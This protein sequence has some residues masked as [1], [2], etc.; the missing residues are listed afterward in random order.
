MLLRRKKKK[1]KPTTTEKNP[2]PKH[3]THREKKKPTHKPT[4]KKN[5]F[6]TN[7]KKTLQANVPPLAVL[8]DQFLPVRLAG[9]LSTPSTAPQAAPGKTL[10]FPSPEHKDRA[11]IFS[12]GGACHRNR[13]KTE[14]IPQPAPDSAQRPRGRRLRAD[15]LC[16]CPPPPSGRFPG[17]GGA[18]GSSQRL[19]PPP[20]PP[21]GGSSRHLSA[22]G[23]PPRLHRIPPTRDA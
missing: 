13:G 9:G 6:E 11:A 20:P 16:T 1:T 3:H 22:G 17:A 2:K 4:N 8:A 21:S 19:P 23:S 14:A 7:R 5:Q 18:A 12:A 15:R 10:S